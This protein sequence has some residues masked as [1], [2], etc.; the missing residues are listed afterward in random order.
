MTRQVGTLN[1]LPSSQQARALR[2]NNII[3]IIVISGS[4]A[5]K[6]VEENNEHNA[7]ELS[8]LGAII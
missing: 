8:I 1:V 5:T 6:R 3:A 4:V 7:T 2:Q